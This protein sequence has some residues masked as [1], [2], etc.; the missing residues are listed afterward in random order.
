MMP[1]ADDP[2]TPLA[3]RRNHY[4]DQVAA[5]RQQ[6]ADLGTRDDDPARMARRQLLAQLDDLYI[7]AAWLRSMDPEVQ[8]LRKAQRRADT[9]REAS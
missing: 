3:R 2:R 4:D 1:P 9:L 6:L 8:R 7:A 5:L